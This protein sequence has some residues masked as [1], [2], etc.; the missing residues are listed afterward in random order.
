MANTP[1]GFPFGFYVADNSPID[2]KYGAI[3]SGTWRPYN[4]IA[5]AL[6]VLPAGVRYIGLTINIAN[7]EYWWKTGIT[8]GDLT[9]KLAAGGGT[10]WPL[11]G[12]ALLSS[13]VE[14]SGDPNGTGPH[15]V[16]LG[17]Q[18]DNTKYLDSFHA[19]SR[20]GNV[21]GVDNG[22]AES[23][24]EMYP[25][26]IGTYMDVGNHYLEYLLTV[27]LG[28]PQFRANVSNGAGGSAQLTLTPSSFGIGSTVVNS[29]V[30]D[31]ATFSA[32]A[33]G[34]SY[35]LQKLDSNN[36]NNSRSASLAIIKGSGTGPTINA[37]Y[38][39]SLGHDDV[40]SPGIGAVKTVLRLIRNG[41]G[42]PVTAGAGA[43]LDFETPVN[44]ASPEFKIMAAIDSV[45]DNV[46]N[47]ASFAS[48]L[49]LYTANAGALS[50]RLTINNKGAEYPGD[51]SSLWT[52]H[53]LVTKKWVQ[54][55]FSGGGLSGLTTN[56]IPYATG[57]TTIGD[58]SAL[59]WDPTNDALTIGTSRIHSRGTRNLFAGNTAGNFTLSGATDNCG[60]GYGALFSITSGDHNTGIGAQVLEDLTTASCNVAVGSLALGNVVSS[61]N[62]TAI[63]YGA[64][65]QTS[66]A[67][68]IFVGYQAGNNVTS[69]AAN[70]IIGYDISA[71]SATANSQLSIQNIIFGTGNSAT[72]TTVSSGNIGI[73]IA[74]PNS[75]L[76]V[77]GSFAL[78]YIEVSS[79]YTAQDTDFTIFCTGT[80]T[81]SLPTA[82]GRTGRIYVIKHFGS[83]TLTV[84][85][86]GSETIDG[87]LTQTILSN[88]SCAV[89]STGTNWIFM[90]N[91]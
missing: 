84:D 49:D 90:I 43:R 26:A 69:G 39:P 55:N 76:Q 59:T 32:G 78:P 28:V 36:V 48:H 60:V 68:N 10:F 74:A 87:A 50:K 88:Q 63:G 47:N 20:N 53:S 77:N 80:F 44:P 38:T 4:N 18:Y 89:Q 14:I 15:I 86:N 83:G 61:N 29:G 12:N 46:S 7:N 3:A 17:G 64:G 34:V 62:N 13:N 58:D 27:E 41:G 24:F 5:E 35:I 22:S 73:R 1:L 16:S 31:L 54:D 9:E 30:T 70:I 79:A 75:T 21:L 19:F 57:A 67:N 56:R 82:V 33:S 85:P 81:L 52:D 40:G 25:D 37:D 51:L 6:T 91:I 72:G 65:G 42:I 11:G 23:Y 8:D 2:G 45:F 66:G 71:Q